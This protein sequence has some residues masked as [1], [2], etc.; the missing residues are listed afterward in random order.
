M[1]TD[2]FDSGTMTLFHEMTYQIIYFY[3][4]CANSMN[5]NIRDG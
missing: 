4:V 2:A 5:T 3:G 1:Q